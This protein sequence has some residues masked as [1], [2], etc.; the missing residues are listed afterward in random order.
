MQCAELKTQ[1]ASHGGERGSARLAGSRGQSGAGTLKS[2]GFQMPSRLQSFKSF[3]PLDR[4]ALFKPLERVE[5][6]VLLQRAQE[7]R[8]R[9]VSLP[10]QQGGIRALRCGSIQPDD[11]TF[12]RAEMDLTMHAFARAV[13]VRG[14]F[15]RAA[16]LCSWPQHLWS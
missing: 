4:F 16:G 8:L 5:K 6:L 9:M 13:Q 11:H 1:F 3:K 10:G 7:A 14:H 2:G 15:N 12:I